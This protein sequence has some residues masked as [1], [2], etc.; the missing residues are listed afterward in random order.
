MKY[1]QIQNDFN[2]IEEMINNPN[3]IVRRLYTCFLD[4]SYGFDIYEKY[5]NLWNKSNSHKKG[6]LL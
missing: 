1:Q 2:D 4:G 6:G 3:H 5:S